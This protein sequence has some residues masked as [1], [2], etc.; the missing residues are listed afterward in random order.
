MTI[1]SYF[2]YYEK[3]SALAAPILLTVFLV[4]NLTSSQIGKRSKHLFELEILRTVI[5]AILCFI[6]FVYADGPLAPCWFIFLV[7]SMPTGILFYAWTNRRVPAYL[8]SLFL[9]VDLWAANQAS[10]SPLDWRHLLLVMAALA[11]V[12]ALFIEFVRVLNQ[13]V[14]SQN[15]ARNQLIQGNKMSALGEMAGGIAHEINTPLAIIQMTSSQVQEILNEGAPDKKMLLK[16]LQTIEQ[17]A[18]RIGQIVTA[19]R[20]FSRDSSRDLKQ[21]VSIVDIVDST[22]ALCLEKFKQNNVEVRISE[23]NLQLAVRCRSTQISQ[24]LLNLLSNSYDAIAD[25]R[26]KWIAVNVVEKE[27]TVELSVIDCGHGVPREIQER[28]FLPFFSTKEIGK[29]TGLGLSISRTLIEAEGGAL[30]FDP[31]CENTCF[32]ISLPKASADH[33]RIKNKL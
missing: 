10:V 27:K 25:F 21:L 32:V 14:E 33:V 1:M 24:A 31:L 22:L 28:I 18:V 15:Q 29:G 20:T 30:S 2:Y 5:N 6:I 7:I 4:F 11:M 9:L 19:L 13:S 23:I 16:M 17:T 3:Q 12:S 26:Q 8:V